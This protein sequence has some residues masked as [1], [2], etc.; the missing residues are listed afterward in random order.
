[1]ALQK[2][3]LKIAIVGH[4]G[5]GAPEQFNDLIDLRR[6]RKVLVNQVMDRA[7][8][9]GHVDAGRYKR[10]SLVADRAVAL[11]IDGADLDDRILGGIGAG[12]LDVDAA[13]GHDKW[14]M[15]RICSAIVANCESVWPRFNSDPNITLQIQQVAPNDKRFA[16][17]PAPPARQ[18]R[19]T[20]EQI[21]TPRPT[22]V[23]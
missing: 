2:R 14:L 16:R 4:V 3:S 12:G 7:G 13:D 23:A 18:A 15:A 10:G 11:Q 5:V 8:F 21:S 1:M 20:R 17:Q 22:R 6:A 19:C 9:C